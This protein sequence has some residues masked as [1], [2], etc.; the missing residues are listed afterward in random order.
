MGA[1]RDHDLRDGFITGQRQIYDPGDQR[2]AELAGG[3]GDSV[4]VTLDQP[5]VTRL[6]A[7]DRQRRDRQLLAFHSARDPHHRE[8]EARPQIKLRQGRYVLT[9]LNSANGTRV[10]GQR[11][12][13][14]VLHDGDVIQLAGVEIR[15]QLPSLWRASQ[16]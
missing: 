2:K 6:H 10:N 12:S 4:R 9:D 3:V 5:H 16:G 15:F 7:G 14:H 13:E 1:P 11:V 8:R